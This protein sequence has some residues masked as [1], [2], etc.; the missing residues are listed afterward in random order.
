MKNLTTTHKLRTN[1]LTCLVFSI[2]L[3]FA[4]LNTAYQ[5]Y[6]TDNKDFLIVG[7]FFFLCLMIFVF[8]YRSTKIELLKRSNHE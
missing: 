4:L 1:L 7:L 6:L 8:S 3:V 5:Y 2:L